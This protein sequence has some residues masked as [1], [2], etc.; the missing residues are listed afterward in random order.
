MGIEEIKFAKQI[1]KKLKAK[2]YGKPHLYCQMC[3]KQ[4]RDD[5]G[6]K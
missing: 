5:V 2:G 3:R 1:G 4:C 6:F